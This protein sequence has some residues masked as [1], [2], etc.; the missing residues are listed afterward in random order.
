M[1]KKIVIF[2]IAMLS[3]ILVNQATLKLCVLPSPITTENLVDASVITDHSEESYVFADHKMPFQKS[4]KE[5]LI[6]EDH[7]LTEK[8]VSMIWQPPKS[9]IFI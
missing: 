9:L 4:S 2:L 7:S 8:K 6:E 5:Y 1:K 3:V